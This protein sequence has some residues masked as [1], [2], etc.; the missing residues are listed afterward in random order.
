MADRTYHFKV[1]VYDGGREI[2]YPDVPVISDRGRFHAEDVGLTG[3]LN[4]RH[5]RCP[6]RIQF[7]RE[8]A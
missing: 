6:V 5:P 2:S 8:T 1:V 4:E 7:I 3:W